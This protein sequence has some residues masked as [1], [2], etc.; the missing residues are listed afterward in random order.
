MKN[1]IKKSLFILPAWIFAASVSAQEA[2]QN[3]MKT[4]EETAASQTEAM[5]SRLDAA[6][7]QIEKLGEIN[8]DFAQK[9]KTAK[10]SNAPDA[11]FKALYKNRDDS[12]KV[13]LG[14]SEFDKLKENRRGKTKPVNK[15]L[16]K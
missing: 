7:E 8:L 13:M 11:T 12:L 5:V 6:P 16:K 2:P 1:L 15:T 14:E 4:P 9:I 10:E 3:K